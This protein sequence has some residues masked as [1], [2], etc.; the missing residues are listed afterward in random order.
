MKFLKLRFLFIA[1]AT[2]AIALPA[3]HAGG[4]QNEVV[5]TKKDTVQNKI[6]CY[7]VFGMDCPGCQS[8]LEKQVKKIEGVAD[9]K[10]SFKEKQVVIE[11]K[12]GA[13][14]SDSEIEK[15]IKKANF[16]P[17]KKLKSTGDEE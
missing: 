16:T 1:I 9:A 12:S 13:E 10:A 8:A 6:I 15:R 7:E 17:G 5:T 11:L 4:L 3:A 14:V 2:F